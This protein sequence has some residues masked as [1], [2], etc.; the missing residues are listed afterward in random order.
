MNT[1]TKE[2]DVNYV[3]HPDSFSAIVI[4]RLR[5]AAFIIFLHF[6]RKR[7]KREREKEREE[8]ERER[9]GRRRGV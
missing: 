2:R 1:L 5:A 7:L 6:H 3:D 9:G 4:D 8:R